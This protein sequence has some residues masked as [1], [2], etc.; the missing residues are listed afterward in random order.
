MQAPSIEQSSSHKFKISNHNIRRLSH[1][2]NRALKVCETNTKKQNNTE[3][4]PKSEEVPKELDVLILQNMVL[5]GKNQATAH[6]Q[7]FLNPS[8]AKCP[9]FC[10]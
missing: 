9:R 8:H 5:H 7:V 10:C 3:G 4:V 1:P 2:N 6:Q